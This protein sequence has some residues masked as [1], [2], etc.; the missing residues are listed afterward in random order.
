MDNGGYIRSQSGIVLIQFDGAVVTIRNLDKNI[1]TRISTIPSPS[2]S[3]ND[4]ITISNRGILMVWTTAEHKI[5]IGSGDPGVLKV[6]EGHDCKIVKVAITDDLLYVVSVGEDKKIKVWELNTGICL[7]TF[8]EEPTDRI[9][10]PSQANPTPSPSRKMSS[11]RKKKLPTQLLQQPA[12]EDTANDLD[13]P[14]PKTVSFLQGQKKHCDR[15]YYE[16]AY[17]IMVPMMNFIREKKMERV[18]FSGLMTVLAN[19]NLSLYSS[20]EQ[21]LWRI[22]CND[23]LG[24]SFRGIKSL[25]IC[26]DL[27]KNG[28][29]FEMFRIFNFWKKNGWTVEL[30][31]ETDDITLNIIAQI[32][33]KDIR[34]TP[35]LFSAIPVPS[36]TVNPQNNNTQFT[37]IQ[38][39][40]TTN[41][42][43]FYPPC[44]VK[45]VKFEN[46]IPNAVFRPSP[47]HFRTLSS[48]VVNS[49][50]INLT[51][52]EDSSFLIGNPGKEISENLWNSNPGDSVEPVPRVEGGKDGVQIESL[53]PHELS[54]DPW[55]TL[56]S[57]YGT[58]PANALVP[59]IPGNVVSS[60]SLNAEPAHPPNV[61][62]IPNHV[63]LAQTN[64]H[65]STS[66]TTDLDLFIKMFYASQARAHSASTTGLPNESSTSVPW[67]TDGYKFNEREPFVNDGIA[68]NLLLLHANEMDAT[69]PTPRRVDVST[70]ASS[71]NSSA[72]EKINRSTHDT[73]Q[74]YR[75]GAYSMGIVM[76]SP[77][78]ATQTQE[79]EAAGEVAPTDKGKQR[80]VSEN[81]SRW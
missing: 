30:L 38:Q 19:Q 41:P 15:P 77:E 5:H 56:V 59:F 36:I 64:I 39:S 31:F 3:V 28:E 62:S 46:H 60:A 11:K 20:E 25:C 57:E 7:Q 32:L 27:Q 34:Q 14:R 75:M 44:N 50:T 22:P 42:P 6:L 35:N 80:D 78:N 29:L 68:P 52:A 49:G 55:D 81:C 67:N 48:D 33:Q 9:P 79:N 61:Q 45:N 10:V 47:W 21:K 65:P 69:S 17:E 26:K 4:L 51:P 58:T 2:R 71:S 72:K 8:F 13:V 74:P 70:I 37:N 73:P 66:S 23:L 53:W 43:P 18:R 16:G 24:K 54:F 40:A 12:L 1:E 76:D 63:P